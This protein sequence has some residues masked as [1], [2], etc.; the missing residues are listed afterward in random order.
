MNKREQFF[1]DF[2]AKKIYGTKA[3]FNKA[4]K[5]YGDAY[6]ELTEKMNAHPNFECAIKEQKKRSNRAKETYS[7]CDKTFVKDYVDMIGNPTYT[8]EMNNIIA[9]CDKTGENCLP[10]LKSWMIETFESRYEDGR[11]SM[12]EAKEEVRKWKLSIAA[13]KGAAAAKAD[14][15]ENDAAAGNA[16]DALNEAAGF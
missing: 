12:A 8:S 13:E 7:G 16:T 1:V 10:K 2:L 4:G 15:T 3:A 11:F 9:F 5:G 14:S 6:N